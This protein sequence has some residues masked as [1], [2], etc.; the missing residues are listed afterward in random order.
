MDHRPTP[1]EGMAFRFGSLLI[2]NDFSPNRLPPGVNPT[3]N[4][5][6]ALDLNIIFPNFF[7]DVSEGS[8]FTY[9]MWPLA[10]DR[11]LW[12]VRNYLMC[13]SFL[14]YTVTRPSRSSGGRP[15]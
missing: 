12:E 15:R 11:T 9:N 6:W 14:G 7:V 10:V 1:V 2:R 5:A 8:Y 4:P 3:K 13:D